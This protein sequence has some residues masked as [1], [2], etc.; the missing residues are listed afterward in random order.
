MNGEKEVLKSIPFTL[1]FDQEPPAFP[2]G[3]EVNTFFNFLFFYLLSQEWESN[4]VYLPS[5]GQMGQF[6]AKF[7]QNRR[8]PCLRFFLHFF[9]FGAEMWLKTGPMR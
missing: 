6:L 7:Q 5:S 8:V 1:L 4:G 3:I 9:F 2:Q